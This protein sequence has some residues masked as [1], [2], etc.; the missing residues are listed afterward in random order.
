MSVTALGWTAEAFAYPQYIA[1][2]YTSCGSCHYSPTGG[3][4]PNSYGH[5]AV[6]ATFPDEMAFGGVERLRELLAKQ[7]VTGRGADG[8][9]ELHFDAGLDSRLLLL[10]VPREMGASPSPVLIPM[11]VEVGGVMAYGAGFAYATITPQPS[12]G[13]PQNRSYRA[14]SREH[15][16]QYKVSE[17][18]ALR[19]GRMVLPFGLRIADHSQPTR[20]D[21]GFNKYDQ[22]YALAWELAAEDFLVSAAVFAGSELTTVDEWGGAATFTYLLPSRLAIGASLLGSEAVASTRLAASVFARWRIWD[23]A[24]ALAEVAGQQRSAKAGGA[25]MVEAATL[26]RVGYFLMESLDA[27]GQLGGRTI[28]DAYETTKL[29]YMLGLDWKALPWVEL[30]PAYVFEEDVEGGPSHQALGQ[31][32]VFW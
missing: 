16:L 7:D 3:G 9:P 12:T 15:W 17:A 10:T 29:R 23:S 8:A 5:L 28:A 32:H 4:L 25:R 21:F 14:V 27:Y 11:L 1:K 2:G 31:L 18:Q 30:S 13:A 19:A 20:E 6:S 22:R 26:L 24:Y